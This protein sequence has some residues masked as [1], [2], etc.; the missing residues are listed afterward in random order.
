MVFPVYSLFLV[1]ITGAMP[2]YIAQKVSYY[3]AK[4][5]FEEINSLL[6]NS[7]VIAI[8]FSVVFALVLIIFAKNIATLQ[9]NYNAYLGYITVS[10]SLI[11][12]SITSIFRG[13]FQGYEN[14]VPSAISGIV[15]QVFKLIVGLSL[16]FLFN[17]YGVIYAVSG[18]FLGILISEIASFV[19]IIFC[20]QLKRTQKSYK[21]AY[22]NFRSSKNIFYQFLPL[23]L[24][25][26]IMPFS[27]CLDSF[28]VVNLLVKS[29]LSVQ[30]STSLFGIATGMINP[31]INFPILLC[32]TISVAM[33][34]TLTF[35]I[36]KN[37][38]IKNMV[39]GIYFFVWFLA[40]PCVFGIMA[41]SGN[42]IKIFFPAIE[43]QYFAT[44]IFYLRVSTLNIIFM[45]I[46][47]ISSSILNS[48]G[49]FK[50]PLFSQIIGF[51][52][53][54]I[55][56]IFMILNRNINIL[57]L[58]FAVTISESISCLINLYFARKYASINIKIINLIAPIFN[59]LIMFFVVYLLNKY[60]ILNELIKVILLVGI[61][62]VVYLMLSFIFKIISLKNIKELFNNKKNVNKIKYE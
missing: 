35:F 40:I 42:I 59:G 39:N 31:L 19:Y 60:I 55:L 52:I 50:L 10:V 37:K 15:E 2:T 27:V 32:G 21:K 61:G 5:K 7:I 48:F 45:S 20:Y 18:A 33:L 28:L 51:A 16:A 29:G 8:F 25:G 49:K 11:F 23:S 34:P 43:N 6:K 54:F 47:Q 46:M 41:L 44:T 56:L 17:R 9:G 30:T 26:L 58:C 4:N 62:V 14:M 24:N 53:K 12:S 57:A 3:R 36:A 13:Y 22:F 38:D 1:F